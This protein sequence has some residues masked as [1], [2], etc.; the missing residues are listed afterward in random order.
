MSIK[1]AKNDLAR[2]MKDFDTFTKICLNCDVNLCH[3]I[4]ATCFEKLPKV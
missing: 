1:V 2:K 4:V 3:I